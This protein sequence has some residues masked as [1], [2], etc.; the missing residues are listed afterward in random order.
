M[1]ILKLGLAAATA[2]LLANA[3]L[4][5][6]PLTIANVGRSQANCDF[7]VACT[8][9]S[10]NTSANLQYYMQGATA[11]IWTRTLSGQAGSAAAGKTG[12]EYQ[13][14][15][16]AVP[17]DGGSE[18]IFGMLLG[19]PVLDQVNY[20]GN[21]STDLYV[22]TS[23]GSGTIAPTAASLAAPGLLEIDFGGEGICASQA[24]MAF[25]LSSSQGSPATADIRL[26]Q[27]GPI[28][29]LDVTARVPSGAI[30]MQAP[31]APTNL[32]VNPQ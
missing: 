27:S 23:G 20:S 32:R 19:F 14:D 18:C 3:P 12:Y 4:A 2:V 7:D 22:V 30:G 21:G 1:K 11:Q 25:G 10:T 31:S 28:P 8:A 16:S 17:V 15:L 26:L 29:I 9:A 13:I 24:S 6:A 5:A